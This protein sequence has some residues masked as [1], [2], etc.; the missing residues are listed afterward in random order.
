VG[1]D[2]TYLNS[3]TFTSVLPG[4][5]TFSE[6][7]PTTLW[8]L[9]NVTCVEGEN[10]PYLGFTSTLTGITLNLPAG[11]DIT[12]TFN[13]VKGEVLG[14]Q[15][16]QVLAKTGDNSTYVQIFGLM[17]LLGSFGVMVLSKTKKKY[18]K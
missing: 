11:R 1:A 3:K 9:K 12:C 4:S 16:G 8:A 15:T 18:S 14:E 10:T 7:N 13:N 2:N 17:L 6:I 5:Y